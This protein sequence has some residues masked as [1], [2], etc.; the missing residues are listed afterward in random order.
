M[1]QFK[2]LR[3][4]IVRVVFYDGK[5]RLKTIREHDDRRGYATGL[6]G[7]IDFLNGALPQNEEI[8]KALRKA[9]PMFPEPAIRLGLS[10]G[11]GIYL[12]VI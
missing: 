5:S 2:G 4:K 12:M 7:L 6:Q 10:L 11:A 8:G 3:R 1:E 9:M